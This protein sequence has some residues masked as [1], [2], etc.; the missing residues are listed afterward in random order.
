MGLINFSCPRMHLW[1]GNT[2]TMF[3]TI[4]FLSRFASSCCTVFATAYQRQTTLREGGW[5]TKSICCVRLAAVSMRQSTICFCG[6]LFDNGCVFFFSQLLC[7][8][9][10]FL[11]ILS[12][13]AYHNIHSA[14]LFGWLIFE[15]FRRKGTTTSSTT[16][17]PILLSFWT[18]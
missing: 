8:P 15:L 1:I 5:F 12:M 3:G 13:A 10:P 14:R 16:R 7:A 17:H 4:I 9:W 18:K 11:S 6:L 2:L